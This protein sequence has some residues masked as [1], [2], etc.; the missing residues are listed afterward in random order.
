[1]RNTVKRFREEFEAKCKKSLH[2][3]GAEVSAGAE[4]AA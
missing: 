4:T 2:P 3:T 1:V